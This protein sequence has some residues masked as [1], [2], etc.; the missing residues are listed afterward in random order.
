MSWCVRVGVC[1]GVCAGACVWACVLVRAC[2]RVCWCVRVG[3]CPGA[4]VWA[5]V[6]VHVCGRVGEC[7]CVGVGACVWACVRVRVCWC[8]CV[9]GCVCGVVTRGSH[10]RGAFLF[11]HAPRVSCL[12]N[13]QWARRHYKHE[14]FHQEVPS[15]SSRIYYVLYFVSSQFGMGQ[16]SFFLLRKFGPFHVFSMSSF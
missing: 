2:G 8:V 14:D 7:V 11:H 13:S 16:T 6:L 4:C 9:G 1:V 5:C 10:P 12:K 3:V 15:S